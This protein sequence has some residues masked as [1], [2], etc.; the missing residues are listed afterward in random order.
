LN[1]GFTIGDLHALL[2]EFRDRR[3]WKK[4]HTLKNL[5]MSVSIESAELLELFQWK[6]DEEVRDAREDDEFVQN[7]ADE[8]ADVLIYLILI[9]G[10]LGIDPIEAARTK[11]ARNER[12]FP[13][14]DKPRVGSEN[15]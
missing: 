14:D 10:E 15:G 11:I 9:A 7:A 8:I 3:D 13:P 12:R 4:F 2:T 1:S 5:A 6:T